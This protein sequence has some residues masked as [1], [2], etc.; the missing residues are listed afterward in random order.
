[1]T[2][3]VKTLK[4]HV[5]SQR[6]RENRAE[7]KGFEPDST[8]LSPAPPADSTRKSP[9]RVP[10]A[11]PQNPLQFRSIPEI[12]TRVPASPD[13]APLVALVRAIARQIGIPGV[14]R[15]LEGHG[16]DWT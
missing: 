13:P 1:M 14:L 12:E 8:T 11:I 9:A 10:E 6:N 16:T 4:A 5:R 2:I 3:K 15:A 7:E